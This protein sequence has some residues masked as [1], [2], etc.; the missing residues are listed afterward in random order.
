[1]ANY[2]VPIIRHRAPKVST[3][4]HPWRGKKR[5]APEANAVPC[6]LSH[7]AL[8]A[9]IT[10]V[11]LEALPGA[12]TLTATAAT[13]MELPGGASVAAGALTATAFFGS[14]L[15]ADVWGDP[16]VDI[17]AN[18]WALIVWVPR[19]PR[20]NEAAGQRH[21]QWTYWPSRQAAWAAAQPYLAMTPPP[22]KPNIIDIR[23]A[24]SKK[25]H[26]D[27]DGLD[28]WTVKF[29]KEAKAGEARRLAQFNAADR[30]QETGALSI[31]TRDYGTEPDPR[32]RPPRAFHAGPLSARH[33]PATSTATAAATCA[34]PRTPQTDANAEPEKNGS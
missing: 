15:P 22:P 28:R 34:A 27:S 21:P 14:Y 23:I 19:P 24:G 8:N 26:L 32:R 12:G 18:P 17:V 2:R 25:K 5:R 30:A 9:A 1:M 3:A 31:G 7:G 33:T 11:T 6:L 20:G 13:R 16:Q 10:P 4:S 29:R